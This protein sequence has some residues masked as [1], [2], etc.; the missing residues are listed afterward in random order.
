MRICLA[1]AVTTATCVA[2]CQIFHAEAYKY[3]LGNDTG[4]GGSW[5]APAITG[6]CTGNT[7]S[8]EDVSCPPSWVINAGKKGSDLVSCCSRR[9]DGF[10]F[11]AMTKADCNSADACDWQSSKC[12]AKYNAT[13]EQI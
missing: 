9:A 12:T 4:T 5:N 1:K 11:A 13:D 6:M 7:N 8:T 10:C 2:V 3:N